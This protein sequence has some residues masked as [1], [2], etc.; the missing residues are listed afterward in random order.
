MN[1][2]PGRLLTNLGNMLFIH[3]YN[4]PAAI[5][6]QIGINGEGI[7]LQMTIKALPGIY[8]RS[9]NHDIGAFK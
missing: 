2:V 8:S 4:E 7:Y 9:I 3:A 5:M 6:L 1:W